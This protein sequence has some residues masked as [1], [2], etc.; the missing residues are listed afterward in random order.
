MSDPA[1]PRRT[2]A[3]RTQQR[4]EQLIREAIRVFGQYGFRGA[5]LAEIARAAGVTEPGLLHHFPRKELLLM[6]VLAER[7]RLDGERFAPAAPGEEGDPF[8]T[9]LQLVKYNET[10]P[11]LVQ[12]FTVL[13][14]ESID[15]QHPGHEFFRQRY[16]AMREQTT[17]VIRKGQA[18]GEIRSDIPA[19]DLEMMLFAMMDGLQVQWLYAPEKVDMAR[20]FEQFVRLLRG[21]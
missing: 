5:T 7:D 1:K 8:E 9:S 2:Q 16:Q 11:G 19:E 12:L 13:V 4:K 20:I 17:E 10:V 14:A 6:E 21:K 3:E 18:R 15:E